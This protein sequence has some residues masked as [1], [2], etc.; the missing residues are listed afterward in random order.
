MYKNVRCR[1]DHYNM[2]IV[3]LF[4]EPVLSNDLSKYGGTKN[5]SYFKKYFLVNLYI[6]AK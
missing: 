3:S 2:S 4:N 6:Y 5:I 1:Y